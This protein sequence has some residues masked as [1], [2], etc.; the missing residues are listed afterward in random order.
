MNAQYTNPH[1][2]Q[3]LVVRFDCRD[4]LV[5]GAALVVIFGGGVKRVIGLS[6]ADE[7]DDYSGLC[8]LVRMVTPMRSTVTFTV[9][10]PQL[11][12]VLDSNVDQQSMWLSDSQ[13]D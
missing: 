3:S 6:Q 10:R 7:I 8:L 2:F 9:L 13:V 5:Y 1:E 11:T 12:K 4:V